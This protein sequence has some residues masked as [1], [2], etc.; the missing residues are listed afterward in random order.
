M[1]WVDDI[2]LYTIGTKK[3]KKTKNMLALRRLDE[4][5]KKFQT[6]IYLAIISLRSRFSFK[7][8]I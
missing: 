8:K 2:I 6:G 1:K 3:K 5:K 7:K 4:R